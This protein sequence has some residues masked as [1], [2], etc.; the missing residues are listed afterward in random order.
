MNDL[1]QLKAELVKA[2]SVLIFLPSHPELDVVAAGLA[3]FLTLKESGKDVRIATSSPPLARDSRLVGIDKLEQEIGDSNLVISFPFEEGRVEKVAYNEDDKSSNIVVSVKPG[4]KIDKNEISFVYA[5]TSSDMVIVAGGRNLSST[6]KILTAER[7]LLEKS[8]LVNISNQDSAFGA[9]NIV[10]TQCSLS[11]LMAAL[12]QEIGLP[13]TEDAAN[14][15]LSGI[16]HATDN[17][18]SDNL[19]ADT[20]EAIAVLYRAGA[21]R[22]S[23]NLTPD[24]LESGKLVV[25]EARKSLKPSSPPPVIDNQD[26]ELSEDKPDWMGPKI[27]KGSTRV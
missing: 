25:Q 15:L 19:T 14:N 5:G 4:R 7:E 24:Q 8:T 11:E 20:F 2:K 23:G 18:Q 10:D 21:R 17:L 16:Y 9:I 12:I 3:L 13:L 22:T 26:D 27:F 6:G 1:E